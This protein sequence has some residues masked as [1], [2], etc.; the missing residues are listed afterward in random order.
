MSDIRQILEERPPADSG[1]EELPLV[2]HRRL[3]RHVEHDERSRAFPAAGATKLVTTHHHR[4]SGP[5]NQGNLGSCTGNALVGCLDTAPFTH[6]RL[7]ERTAVKLYE[8]ATKLDGFPGEYPPDDTGSS[9]LA[10]CKAGKQ[11]GYISAYHHAFGLDHALQALVLGPEIIGIDWYDSFDEP[12]A[13]GELVIAPGAQVR[14]G[15]ELEVSDIDVE[16]QMIEGWQSWGDWGPLHGR[17]R[18]SW[19]TFGTLLDAHG[20]VTVPVV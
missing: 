9:G 5:F 1:L 4:R 17:W 3:G 16:E 15:H 18:M 2:L 19:N 13:D 7:G 6:S 20:D 14:G 8:L 11:D 12:T 10:I